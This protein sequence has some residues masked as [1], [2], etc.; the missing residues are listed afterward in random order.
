M[1]ELIHYHAPQTRSSSILWLLE[2]LGAKRKTHLLNLKKAE[3]K[4]P[5]YL[6]INP[7]GKVPAITHGGVPVTEAPA[8]A[9]Y[10][11]DALPEA[12]LAPDVMDTARGTYLR[13]LVFNSSC[14]EPALID[15]ALKREGGS[16]SMLPYGDAA[17][18]IDALAG[19][20][21]KGPYILG[22][23]F[24]AA[25]VIIGSG[26]RW[27]LMFKLLPD[28][29]EFTSYVERLSARPALQRAMAMD[30]AFT[31]QQAVG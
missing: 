25:D 11:A 8:I 7:M 30:E 2:E 22:D 28:R 14:V 12:K 10:L 23:A 16:P 9:M 20:L 24:S 31:A 1:P 26:V 18:T 4:E 29:P 21:A 5:W 3:H 13:W 6:A 15:R 19:A 27:M 17:T